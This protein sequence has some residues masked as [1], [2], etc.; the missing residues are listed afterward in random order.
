M[1]V[2]QINNMTLH[3]EADDMLRVYSPDKRCL[4]EFRTQARAEEWM[5]QTTDFLRHEEEFRL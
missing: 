4:E 3:K 2:K 1:K 5:R